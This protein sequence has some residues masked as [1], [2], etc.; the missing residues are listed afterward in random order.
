MLHGRHDRK[1]P[2]G[3]W[4]PGLNQAYAIR[5][6][7][8]K[9]QPDNFLRVIWRTPAPQRQRFWLR[10]VPAS[11]H[12]DEAAAQRAPLRSRRIPAFSRR[13]VGCR[14]AIG[15]DLVKERVAQAV[16]VRIPLTWAL[17]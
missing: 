2:R 17:V 7:S 10:K 5:T 3:S 14:S 16:G 15:F 1:R 13:W 6:R 8:A 11:M 12:R 9:Q 4:L